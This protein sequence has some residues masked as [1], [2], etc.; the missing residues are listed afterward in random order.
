MAPPALGCTVAPLQD[1]WTEEPGGW[2]V[3]QAAW[4]LATRALPGLSRARRSPASCQRP[5]SRL[6]TVS[7]GAWMELVGQG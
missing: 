1:V 4:R 6:Q 3:G 2:P 5:G 7:R